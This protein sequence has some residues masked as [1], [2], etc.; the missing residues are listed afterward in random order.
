MLYYSYSHDFARERLWV[1]NRAFILEYKI[2]LPEF[3]Y[4]VNDF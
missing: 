4:Y 3:R 1:D 2:Q